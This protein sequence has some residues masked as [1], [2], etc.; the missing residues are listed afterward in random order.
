MNRA[1]EG[2]VGELRKLRLALT[3]L[4]RLPI[5]KKRDTLEGFAGAVHVI[6]REA[7]EK[8]RDF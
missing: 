8:P 6:A 2:Y 1:V 3:R 4:S 7:L 5:D